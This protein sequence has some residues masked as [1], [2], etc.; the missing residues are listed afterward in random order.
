MNQKNLT[1]RDSLAQ[2]LRAEA[3][4][5]MVPFSNSLHQRIMRDLQS[6]R[7]LSANSARRRFWPMPALAAAAGILI[8]VLVDR[9]VMVRQAPVKPSVAELNFPLNALAKAISPIEDRLLQARFGYVDQDA[10]RLAR[11]VVSQ[12]DVLPI[13]SQRPGQSLTSTNSRGRT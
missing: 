11:F 7:M 1:D 10:T 13:G 2:R 9:E 6:A 3:E 12:L 5:G 8:G 4:E